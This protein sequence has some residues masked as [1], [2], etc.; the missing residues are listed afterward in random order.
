MIKNAVIVGRSYGNPGKDSDYFKAAG[1]MTS[2]DDKMIISNVTFHNFGDSS[3]NKFVAVKHCSVCD[4]ACERKSEP[5]TLKL[6]KISFVNV[7]RKLYWTGPRR[8]IVH[9]IDGSFTGEGNTR[10]LTPYEPHLITPDC[11]KSDDPTYD[12]SVICNQNV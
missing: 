1:I 10:W 11:I 7:T 12:N 4:N 9:D 8:H 2:R 6:E 3:H 5:N